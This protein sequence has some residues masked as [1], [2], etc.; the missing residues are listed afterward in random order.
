MEED[1]T[2]GL[3]EVE[4]VEIFVELGPALL[5][6]ADRKRM[7][8]AFLTAWRH[9]SSCLVESEDNQREKKNENNIKSRAYRIGQI[10]M[11]DESFLFPPD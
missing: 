4:V 6:E 7:L 3:L 10:L 1:Q 2:K 5:V 9:S 11:V 8:I